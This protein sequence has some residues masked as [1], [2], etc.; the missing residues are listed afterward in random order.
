MAKNEFAV[1]QVI[2]VKCKPLDAWDC[3]CDRTPTCLIP[4]CTAQKSYADRH[5]EW[6][7]VM[8]NGEL[9]CIKEAEF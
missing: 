8:S 4:Y 6:Y 7:A 3:D 2:V 5:Y 1:K 9:Q